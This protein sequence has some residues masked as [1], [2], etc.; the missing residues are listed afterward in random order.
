[1]AGVHR[2]Q[3]IDLSR[4]RSSFNTRC[5]RCGHSIEPAELM[6]VNTEEIKCPA[7]GSVFVPKKKPHSER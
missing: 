7:C 4:V 5:L 1:M 6:R 3:K 2:P